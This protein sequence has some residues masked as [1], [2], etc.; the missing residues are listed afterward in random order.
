MMDDLRLEIDASTPYGLTKAMAELPGMLAYWAQLAG[1]LMVKRDHLRTQLDVAVASAFEREMKAMSKPGER[2][3]AVE[4]VKNRVELDPDV[5]RLREEVLAVE[6]DR[7]RALAGV[8]GLKAKRDM[9]VSIGA[10]IRAEMTAIE[11][12][13]RR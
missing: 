2:S 6:R 13:V 12:S 10:L 1:E 5:N 3:P 9:L 11:P 8:E 4:R 7:A